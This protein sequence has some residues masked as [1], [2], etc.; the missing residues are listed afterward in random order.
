M[1]PKETVDL[2]FE[3]ARVEEI[4]SDFV[5]LK[6]RGVNFIGNCPFHNEKTPSFTVS[7][8]KG[9]YKCFGCGKG[10]NS[11]NFIM[12]IEH[13]S[14]PD[15]LR[16]IA[17]KYN[18]EIQEEELT[19]EQLDKANEKESLF[20]ITKFANEYFKNILWNSEEGKRIGLS[21][22]K[23]RGFSDEIIKKFELGYNPKQKDAF[24]KLA[25]LKGYDKNILVNSGLSL[26]NSK[27]VDLIDR[28]KE[29]AIFPIQSYS[30]RTLGFG[31]RAFNINA[32]AKYLN[33]PETLIYYKSKVL[34]GLNLAKIAIN[35]N[36]LCYIVEGYTDVISMHQVGI[37][38]VV[39]A[40]GTALSVEQIKLINRL[41]KNIVLL[42][43]GDQAGLKATY[44]SINMILRE[45]M[46]VKIASFP[47]GEDPD[48]FSK[49]LSKKEFE[50]FL[51]NMAIDFIDYKLNIS[52]LN[53]ISDP[54]K[55]TQIK[56]DIIHSISFIPDPLKRVQY[57]KSYS[58][59]LEI[60]EELLLKEI[61]KFRKN[62]TKSHQRTAV[63]KVTTT[64]KKDIVTKTYENGLYKLEEEVLRILI[65]Y[66]NYSVLFD[67]EEM[68]V[69]ELIIN[70]LHADNIKFHN[71]M[72]D[73]LYNEIINIINT[74]G[75]LKTSYLI[76]HTDQ[77]I[78]KKTIDLISNKHHI[79]TNWVDRHKIY[80][81]REDEK[82][83]K[84][85]EKAIL[86][87]KKGH[88]ENK[89]LELQEKL[90]KNDISSYEVKTLTQLIK[91]KTTIA[92]SMGRNVG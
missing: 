65:N 52:K 58:K 38:N 13:F 9:I 41:T 54:N 28:F 19:K 59:K 17:K 29:R 70:E 42:F 90:K 22:F 45:G 1:I 82:I 61:D 88:L 36:D 16:Y 14:Y 31:A 87:L 60:D 64:N 62:A 80:T 25:I 8:S 43:D 79:S 73:R 68:T 11:I 26:L 53:S 23:E 6:K 3:T 20:I 92:K 2:I 5:T 84:T 86:S 66:G 74:T 15:A 46:N 21:Y 39:S 89:I 78:N 48:S 72:L 76:K 37:E 71:E 75:K 55:I 4:V 91:I 34:Y 7:P 51:N 63:E 67:N 81:G 57:C 49:K 83:K 85:T 30:G 33:S 40:S 69:A 24:S 50:E 27:S 47:E 10:G 32:K 12:E 18:I 44:K 56:R 35:K 77:N